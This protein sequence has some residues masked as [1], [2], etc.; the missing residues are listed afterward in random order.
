[1]RAKLG[2]LRP[3]SF[4]RM[5]V[6]ALALAVLAVVSVVGARLLVDVLNKPTLRVDLVGGRIQRRGESRQRN[7]D[8]ATTCFHADPKRLVAVGNDGHE[9]VGQPIEVSADDQL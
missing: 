5:A 4:A 8:E 9:I 7:F 1:M 3:P 6:L 2:G